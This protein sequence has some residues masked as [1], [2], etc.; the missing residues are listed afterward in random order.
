L[1]HPR[2]LDDHFRGSSRGHE[3]PLYVIVKDRIFAI[4]NWKR[5][6]IN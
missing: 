3:N 6:Q 4:R 2:L 5:K 1:G